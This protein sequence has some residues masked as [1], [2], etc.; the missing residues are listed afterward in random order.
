M[1]RKWPT[2]EKFQIQS[3]FVAVP[4]RARLFLIVLLVEF[5]ANYWIGFRVL[6]FDKEVHVAWLSGCE[7]DFPQSYT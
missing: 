2:V 4:D 6:P 5:V 3:V 1:V 7:R